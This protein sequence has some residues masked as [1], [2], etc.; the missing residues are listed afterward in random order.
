VIDGEYVRRGRWSLAPSPNDEY[1]I[2]PGL[3]GGAW[4]VDAQIF[5][6]ACG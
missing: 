4:G 1:L 6:A 3:L 5:S 2:Y